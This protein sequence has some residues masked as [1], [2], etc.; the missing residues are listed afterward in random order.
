MTVSAAINAASRPAA[1]SRRNSIVDRRIR[2]YLV[3]KT[4]STIHVRTH[5]NLNEKMRRI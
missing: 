4:Q 3:Y 2:C 1:R 5:K